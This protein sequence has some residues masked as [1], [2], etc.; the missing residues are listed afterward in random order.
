MTTQVDLEMMLET[1][2]G[3]DTATE[4][5]AYLLGTN[6]LIGSTFWQGLVIC[7]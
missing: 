1:C 6:K 4:V 3:A 2:T 7:Q 5:A